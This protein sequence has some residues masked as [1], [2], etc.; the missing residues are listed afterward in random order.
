[1]VVLSQP[2]TV[3]NSGQDAQRNAPCTPGLVL[4]AM[5]AAS[6]WFIVALIKISIG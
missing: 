6:I 2:P 5:I 1:V 4:T 3:S